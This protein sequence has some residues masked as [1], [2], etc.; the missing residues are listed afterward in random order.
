MLAHVALQT[1]EANAHIPGVD[2]IRVSVASDALAKKLLD[3][4]PPAEVVITG[5][6]RGTPIAVPTP[7]GLPCV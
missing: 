2:S 6:L 1:V 4:M 3:G 5:A 7:V